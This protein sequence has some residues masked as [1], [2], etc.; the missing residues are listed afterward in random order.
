MAAQIHFHIHGKG[1]AYVVLAIIGI[2]EVALGAGGTDASEIGEHAPRHFEEAVRRMAPFF[3]G[4]AWA[5]E[6]RTLE[7]EIT[8]AFVY[9]FSEQADALFQNYL[10]HAEAYVGKGKVKDHNTGE[11]LQPDESFLKSIEE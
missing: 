7:R 8:K 5:V 9:S 1:T 2:V 10:D 3:L 4:A 6:R 11:E